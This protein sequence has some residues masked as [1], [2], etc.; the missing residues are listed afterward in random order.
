MR[1]LPR[2]S[3]PRAIIISMILVFAGVPARAQTATQLPLDWASAL[4]S[5]ADKITAVTKR[6]ESLTLEVKNM[7]TQTVAWSRDYPTE[8]PACWPAEDNRLILAWD[9]STLTAKSE[10][11]RFPDRILTKT[12]LA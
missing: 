4:G 9:I 3:L 5:L 2:F 12:G 7:K 8:A 1:L 10:L 11:G 6:G